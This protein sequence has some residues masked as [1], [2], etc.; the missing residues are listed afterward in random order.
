MAALAGKAPAVLT[1]RGVDAGLTV[2][3]LLTPCDREGRLAPRRR[4]HVPP[5]ISRHA[6]LLFST[7]A[8]AASLSGWL[9]GSAACPLP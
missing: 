5:P 4:G 3:V 8:T 7:V 6:H 9:K 2:D 1:S